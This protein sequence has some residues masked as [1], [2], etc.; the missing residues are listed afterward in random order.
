VTP[1]RIIFLD[2][3]G[4]L[5]SRRWF[6]ANR[7]DEGKQST[8]GE[9]DPEAVARVQTLVDRTGASVVISST[10]R[11]LY[12]KLTLQ[13]ILAR[14]GLKA[15]LAG[16]TPAHPRDVRGDEIQAYL[17][18]ANLVPT[19]R[20]A[21]IVILDDDSDMAHLA[22]WLVQTTFADGLMDEHVEQAIEVLQRPAPTPKRGNG[23]PP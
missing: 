18:V 3:D 11:L 12:R 6:V 20:P 5:N 2:I 22:P 15:R 10:W 23:D 1:F 9:L 17:N 7:F 13:S 19:Q 8:L 4:V 21:G 16:T 14:A